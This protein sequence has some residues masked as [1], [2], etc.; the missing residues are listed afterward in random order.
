MMIGVAW[1]YSD[2]P[3][4]LVVRCV[5]LL[6]IPKVERM[7][8]EVIVAK[9][10]LNVKITLNY[11]NWRGWTSGLML[12]SLVGYE[13]TFTL[14]LL[15][16]MNS[17]MMWSQWMS[18]TCYWVVCNNLIVGLFVVRDNLIVGL[19]MMIM[20]TPTHLCFKGQRS[21]CSPTKIMVSHILLGITTIF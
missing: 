14:A 1:P 6:L 16:K 12:R 7:L 15:I 19:F 10:G 8:L 20:L 21:C 5:L 4:L 11:T 13:S 18:A 17:C 9:L 2:Q 3:A